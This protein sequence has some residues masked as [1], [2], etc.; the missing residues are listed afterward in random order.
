M[1][2]PE[3]S[4]MPRPALRKLACALTGLAAF[5]ILAPVKMSACRCPEHVSSASYYKKAQFVVT[6]KVVEVHPN[7]KGDGWTATVAVDRAWKADVPKTI[8]ISTSTDCALHFTQGAEYLLFLFPAPGGG[9]YT[10]TCAGNLA[11]VAAGPR[12]KW[13]EQHASVASTAGS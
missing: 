6:G 11:L 8:S 12:L 3:W 7:A 1:G 2:S 10:S 4:S 13:L 9:Y 5:L